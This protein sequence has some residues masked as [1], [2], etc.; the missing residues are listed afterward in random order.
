MILPTLEEEENIVSVLEDI[1]DAVPQ[2][3][4]LVVDDAGADH[5]ADLAEE[6]SARLGQI[7]V[8]RRPAKAGLGSAYRRGF[9]VALAHGYDAV[10]EMDADGSHDAR[11]LPALLAALGHSD[12]VIGSRYVPG[13]VIPRWAVHR[14][15]LSRGGNQ[16]AG[17]A[18]GTR[19]RD[20]TSGFR[21]YRAEAVR[22]A[23]VTTVRS[24]GYG[25]QIE[26]AAR[27]LGSGGRV[28]EV[29]IIFR[30]RTRGTSKLSGRIVG[31]ALLLCATL[32]WRHRRR[33]SD[34]GRQPGLEPGLGTGQ[35]LTSGENEAASRGHDAA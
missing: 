8:I 6:T 15:M 33:R 13:G 35:V 9:A 26:M 3:D 18:L 21:T 17:L 22:A 1:R 16:L 23:E 14:R 27:V 7:S 30:D 12:L 24:E 31:E 20:L 11:A 34:R 19:V 25:F 2:A 28:V 10:V 4:V 5:T 32:G 29:P